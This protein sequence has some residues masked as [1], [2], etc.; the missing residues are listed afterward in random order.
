MNTDVIETE[1]AV[2][3]Q[4]ISTTTWGILDLE[5]HVYVLTK[6]NKTCIL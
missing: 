1:I 6:H 2:I 4:K 3:D 5:N